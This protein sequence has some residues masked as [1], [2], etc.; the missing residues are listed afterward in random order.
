MK[1]VLSSELAQEVT[2]NIADSMSSNV[3]FFTWEMLVDY[4][5]DSMPTV[6]NF[7]VKLIIAIIVLLV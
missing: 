5:R 6:L 3:Q 7:L 2:E 4:F 1:F